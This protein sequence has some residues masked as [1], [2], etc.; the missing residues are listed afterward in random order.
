[1]IL[2][3]VMTVKENSICISCELVS[4]RF[5]KLCIEVTDMFLLDAI[6]DMQQLDRDNVKILYASSLTSMLK[7][8]LEDLKRIRMTGNKE[9]QDWNDD[10]IIC[11][12]SRFVLSGGKLLIPVVPAQN[13]TSDLD[14]MP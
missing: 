1:M 5:K 14:H 8:S 4:P 11:A 2:C 3:M 9:Y 7:Y 13:T 12:V 10:V 6:N